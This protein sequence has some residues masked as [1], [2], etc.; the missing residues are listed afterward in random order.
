MRVSGRR[1]SSLGSFDARNY[2]VLSP[3]TSATLAV[4]LKDDARFWLGEAGDF[5]IGEITK[6]LVRGPPPY[7]RCPLPDVQRITFTPQGL[8]GPL[9]KCTLYFD[10]TPASSPLDKP[11]QTIRCITGSIAINWLTDVLGYQIWTRPLQ[12]LSLH[13]DNLYNRNFAL[14]NNTTLFPSLVPPVHV[15]HITISLPCHIGKPAPS[16]PAGSPPPALADRLHVLYVWLNMLARRSIHP[17]VVEIVGAYAWWDL[18]GV[19]MRVAGQ[20]EDGLLRKPAIRA[21]GMSTS[22]VDLY[23]RER[24]C[25]LPDRNIRLIKILRKID[26]LELVDRCTTIAAAVSKHTSSIEAIAVHAATTSAPLGR[27][28]TP[29]GKLAPDNVYVVFSDIRPWIACAGCGLYMA[30][31]KPHEPLASGQGGGNTARTRTDQV[32]MAV[33]RWVR[34]R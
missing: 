14:D 22:H 16:I 6:Y 1:S 10:K 23:D 31:R 18:E 27:P 12:S 9:S 17:V 32:D 3:L 2:R 24:F 25:F 7:A 4:P 11:R 33:Y 19:P 29:I 15:N 5:S 8:Y 20:D 34:A 28:K 21:P 30:S 26:R 13:L